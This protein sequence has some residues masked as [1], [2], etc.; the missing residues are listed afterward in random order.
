M[1]MP[2]KVSILP[3]RVPTKSPVI[4]LSKKTGYEVR[5]IPGSENREPSALVG[6]LI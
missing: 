1:F 3:K 6:S 5:I 2:D 4:R